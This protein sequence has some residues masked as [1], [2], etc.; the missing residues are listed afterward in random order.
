MHSAIAST[1]DLTAL[2]RANFAIRTLCAKIKRSEMRK[3]QE[4][5][6]EEK[7]KG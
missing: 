1:T 4:R 7:K 3:E 5:K 6:K 2:L